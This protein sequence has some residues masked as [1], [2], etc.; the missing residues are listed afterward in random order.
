M[1]WFID[2]MVEVGAARRWAGRIEQFTYTPID[3]T[4]E[5][6]SG[7]GERYRAFRAGTP[8]YA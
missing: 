3:A 1:T 8:V 2:R 5:I 7:I 4:P 6:A